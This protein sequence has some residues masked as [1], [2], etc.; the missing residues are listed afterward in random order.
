MSKPRKIMVKKTIL[1]KKNKVIFIPSILN[2]QLIVHHS[3]LDEPEDY[4]LPAINNVNEEE[5]LDEEEDELDFEYNG[6]DEL[7]QLFGR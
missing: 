3:I 6:D 5:I 4:L 2:E 1:K 7:Y